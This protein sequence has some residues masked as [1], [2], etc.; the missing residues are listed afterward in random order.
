ML[1]LFSGDDAKSKLRAYEKLIQSVPGS[2]E[3]FLINRNNFD[4]NELERFYSG[5]GLFFTACMVVFS[6]ILE[7]ET[8]RNLVIKK[9]GPMAKSESLFIFLEGKLNKPVLDAFKKAGAESKVFEL[10]KAKKERFNSFLLAN[11]FEQKD[12]LNL[13]ICY[14]QAVTAGVGMEELAGVLFWKIKDMILKN[15]IRAFS[16]EQLKKFASRLSYVLPEA[17]KTGKDPEVAFERFLLDIF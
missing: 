11:A 14:R 9:L 5:A 1:Y 12:K 8:S 4:V 17:R 2:T 7:T 10:A 3:K 6:D 16:L 13:W 15:N